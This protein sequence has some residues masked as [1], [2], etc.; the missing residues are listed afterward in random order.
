MFGSSSVRC[1]PSCN[2]YEGAVNI[3]ERA[4]S[5]PTPNWPAGTRPLEDRRK[6]QY[7]VI[8]DDNKIVFRL[9]NTN[10]V[11]WYGPTSMRLDSSWDSRLTREFADNFIPAG[12]GFR[13]YQD[14]GYVLTYDTDKMMCRGTHKFYRQDNGVWLPCPR[15]SR[16]IKPRRLVVD[17]DRA[18]EINE[19][20]R[21]FI[22]WIKAMWAVSGNDGHHP[23]VGQRAGWKPTFEMPT[24]FGPDDYEDVVRSHIHRKATW[25]GNTMGTYYLLQPRLVD[26]VLKSIR[27]TAYKA[28]DCYI[29]IDYDAPLPRRTKK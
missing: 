11:E 2:T 23:W 17:K 16:V 28:H 3:F 12:I 4:A 20:L 9:H 25:G 6:T 21:D 24:A 18:A 15:E 14:E 10:I 1:L 26:D 19:E 22:E 29:H 27:T 7:A 5:K 8:R 13:R